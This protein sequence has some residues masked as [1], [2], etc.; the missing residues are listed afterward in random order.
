M[1]GSTD[2]GDVSW[3]VPTIQ[4]RVRPCHRHARTFLAA[5]RPRQDAGRQKGMVHVAKVM[6]APPSGDRGQDADR[7]RQGGPGGADERP[8]YVCPIPAEVKPPIQPRPEAA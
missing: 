8:P 4:A 7:A 1:V 2:V 6:A 5:H 3:K